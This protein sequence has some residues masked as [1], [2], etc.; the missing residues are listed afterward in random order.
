MR[1]RSIA[2]CFLALN[3]V[4]CSFAADEVGTEIPLAQFYGFESLE[5]FKLS[6]RSNNM[7]QG[8]F[9]NDGLIDILIVDNSNSRIDL[10]QQ[11]KTKPADAPDDDDDVNAVE[12]DWRFEHR[13]IPVDKQIAALTA[14]D[15]NN[16]G[17][18]DMAYFA[19]PDRLVIRY[20]PEQGSWVDSFSMR[21]PNV[22]ATSFVVGS[23][24]L[25]SDGRDDVVV[26]GKTET[27]LLYQNA[28]GKLDSPVRLNNT[29]SKLGLLQIA[30]LDGD[31]RD[32]LCY[33]TSEEV[34]NGLCARLQNESGQLGPELRFALN[35][36]RGV[37]LF[38]LDGEPGAEV[39]NIDSRTGRVRVSQLRRPKSEDGELAGRLIQYGF[40]EPGTGKDRDLAIADVN[41]DGLH[42]VVVT[43]P[44]GAQMLVFRQRPDKGL[45]SGNTY[46]GLL[47][48]EQI[49]A[50]DFD[51][52][53]SA[54][55]VVLSTKE[56]TLAV[57][58]FAGGRLSFPKAIPIG[59]TDVEPSAFDTV[60][61]DGDNTP[62]IVFVERKREGRSSKYSLRGLKFESADKWADV[63][64]AG[65]KTSLPLDIKSAPSRLMSFNAN[66]DDK[67]D[68]LM[69]FEAS[70]EPTVLVATADGFEPL[71]TDGGFQLGAVASGAV[72]TEDDSMLLSQ[73]SFTRN[74]KL[75]DNR[76][77]VVDQYNAAET[78]ARIAGSARLDLDGKDG[79]E[80]VLIDS[81][82][83]RL[84][85]LR[86]EDAV[87]R[88][89]REVELGSL[90]FKSVQVADLNGDKRDD[91]LLFG[92]GRFAVLYAGQTDPVLKET[93]S[94]ETK[95]KNVYFTDLVAG[96]LNGDGMADI[97]VMDTRSKY[98]EL[99]NYDPKKGLRHAT[100]FKVFETKG[101]A[102]SDK[103]S[104]VQPREGVIADVTGDGR[105]D[106]ML[107]T[108]DRILL[109]PQDSGMEDDDVPV[110]E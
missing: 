110:V 109:Y 54:E 43:D 96:D 79:K 107:L 108:H 53:G 91:L 58:R 47:G 48:T 52:D 60:D 56:K 103:S 98:I 69:F 36:P 7:H 70:K 26:L 35:R 59:G 55:V 34:D 92:G 61:L 105:A 37:T 72:F 71:V 100:H 24:D 78:E 41:G 64:F 27:Y 23:G 2:V 90:K 83:K 87:Y 82:V 5:I 101:F 44:S 12:S 46:P 81:G 74:I 49:R 86:E 15:F 76:W 42:D 38:N 20:Q 13:K 28:D 4:V 65:D 29:S 85:V 95:L 66:G 97:A 88:P 3:L 9:N 57:S 18:L 62:E 17:R 6:Q 39:L 16:D 102:R 1:T 68:L 89:W 33:L 19:A 11:R 31:G 93:A 80:I 21:L 50:T 99:L 45:D 104:S 84:R 8:D 94:F 77:Q 30:D 14:G 67:A 63:K 32:D 25:N 10:L 75:E 40:G 106:L 73:E 22:T 51:G